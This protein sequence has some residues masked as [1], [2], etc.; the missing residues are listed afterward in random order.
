METRQLHGRRFPDIRNCE[1]EKPARKRQSFRTLDRMNCFDCVL[2]AENSRRLL[3]AKVQGCKLLGFQLKQIDRLAY[4]ITF[5]L[6]VAND[7]A[8]SFVIHDA[9]IRKKFHSP[10]RLSP[11]LNIFAA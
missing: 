7:S 11:A 5:D 4:Q 6:I 8:D 3:S 2:L 9:A 1:G 10:Y